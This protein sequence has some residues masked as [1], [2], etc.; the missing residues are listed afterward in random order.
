M[1]NERD[2]EI[3][4]E[5]AKR[6]AEIAAKN[7]QDERREMWRNQNDFIRV[8]PPVFINGGYT[9][10]LLEPMLVC[11]DPFCRAYEQT[12]RSKIFQD[13]FGD[14]Y[15]IEPWVALRA[16][17]V[18]NPEGIWGVKNDVLRYDGDTLAFHVRGALDS[19]DN[20][21]K[22]A[23]PRHSIDEVKTSENAERLSEM[24]GGIMEIHIDRSPAW[25]G[26]H[27]DI[28]TDIGYLRGH[29]QM[30]WDII[31]EP[32]AMHRLL[33]FMRDGILKAQDEAERAGDYSLAEQGNQAMTYSKTLAPPKP[34]SH[35]SKRSE[36]WAFFAAQEYAVISPEQHDEF[37][38]QYQL[39]IMEKYGLTAYG[40]CEDLTRKIGI[41]RKIK[42]LRRISV[43]P[44][45]DARA[46]AE[47]IGGDYVISY[48]PNP[49]LVSSGYDEEI[50]RKT[51]T[52]D[53][54]AFAQ[55]GC[56]VDI[57]LKDVSSVERKPERLLRFTEIAKRVAE[58]YNPA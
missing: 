35:G 43:T 5:L 19:L 56:F 15:I 28:S 26:W 9:R 8:R 23:V 41:L 42:N 6:T 14:D 47:Q 55:N 40:C 21:S 48:R 32:E 45:A 24:I 17:V 53:M 7:V 22:M 30:L 51:L 27:A 25:H 18:T 13:T 34:N 4:R 31:D 1:A 29:E 38:L 20:V 46:C 54:K 11:E 2:I 44:F 36:M 16:S 37:L 50:I 12:F 57:C 10:E 58:D 3:V 39:P 49:S 33:A 52:R